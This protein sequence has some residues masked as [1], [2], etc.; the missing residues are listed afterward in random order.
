MIHSA[1][2]V[3]VKARLADEVL[4]AAVAAGLVV[5]WVEAAA[6]DDDTDVPAPAGLKE[7]G[8]VRSSPPASR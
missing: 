1:G 3:P 2:P 7:M 8:T 4:V 6:V 5:D